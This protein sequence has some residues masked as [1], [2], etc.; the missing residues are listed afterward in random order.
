MVSGIT[1]PERNARLENHMIDPINP[2]PQL[3][4]NAE[5]RI[6]EFEQEA[7]LTLE[8]IQAQRSRID[9]L[10][11]QVEH[12]RESHIRFVE[13]LQAQ[14]ADL[15]E[16]FE[17]LLDPLERAHSVCATLQNETKTPDTNYTTDNHVTRSEQ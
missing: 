9:E 6:S 14:I 17:S 10:E 11:Q 13:R 16:R 5:K 15:Q 7:E 1:N 2:Y 12:M 8:T 3:L 4:Q